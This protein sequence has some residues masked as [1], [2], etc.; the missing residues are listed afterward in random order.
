MDDIRHSAVAEFRGGQVPGSNKLSQRPKGASR[1][2]ITQPLAFHSNG[3][4]TTLLH[5]NPTSVQLKSEING[6]F[7]CKRHQ[8]QHL[9]RILYYLSTN[10]K[11]GSSSPLGAPPPSDFCFQQ[12]QAIP[13]T[14]FRT[15]VQ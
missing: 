9:V 14:S 15:Q 12:L 6:A 7:L 10:Q 1:E 5:F 8:K 2:I 11:V 13:F 3:A 4:S